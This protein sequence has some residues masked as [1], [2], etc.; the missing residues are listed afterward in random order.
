MLQAPLA[1]MERLVQP[2]RNVVVGQHRVLVISVRAVLQVHIIIV[3]F[4]VPVMVIVVLMAHTN[5]VM[6][7]V[8]VADAVLRRQVP[9]VAH[10]RQV[11]LEVIVP[12]QLYIALN[13]VSYMMTVV[14]V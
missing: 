2:Q 12:V 10:H 1:V 9:A 13:T 11:R 14:I 7:F 8:V 6:K 3:G 5:L 4:M